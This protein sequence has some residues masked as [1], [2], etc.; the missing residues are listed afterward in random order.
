MASVTL[1]P[2]Q[3]Y[4][5]ANTASGGYSLSVPPDQTYATGIGDNRAV[6]LLDAQGQVVDLVGFAASGQFEGVGIP[7]GPTANPSGQIS[8]KRL[9]S[10][11]DS[12]NNAQDF[13][14]GESWANPQN[15]Q[16]PLY[17]DN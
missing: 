15:R 9:P 7:D 11:K 16:S 17:G 12:D 10:G 4:L 6:R 5:L 2:G 8:W 13:F 1:E 14:F 3:Y